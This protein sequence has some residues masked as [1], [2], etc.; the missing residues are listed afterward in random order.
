MGSSGDGKFRRW[1]V[2]EMGVEEMERSTDGEM[3][4][5]RDV[6]FRS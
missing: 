2:G 4:S 6:E 1:V 3:G 5:S